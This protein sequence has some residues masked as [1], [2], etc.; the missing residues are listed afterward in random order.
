MVH[1]IAR[2]RVPADTGFGRARIGTLEGDARTYDFTADTAAIG[3]YGIN[4]TVGNLDFHTKTWGLLHHEDG[5]IAL[6]PA[7][8]VIPQ[9]RRICRVRLLRYAPGAANPGRRDRSP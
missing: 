4:S 7:Y 8:D 2:L 9:G 3:R 5:A 6:A 1:H